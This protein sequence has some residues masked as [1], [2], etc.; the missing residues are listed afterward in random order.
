MSL[1]F[2]TLELENDLNI[3]FGKEE[4]SDTY[5]RELLSGVRLYETGFAVLKNH[6]GTLIDTGGAAGRMTDTHRI[7][8]TNAAGGHTGE[9][10]EVELDNTYM[11]AARSLANGY[12]IYVAAPKREVNAEV[13]ASLTRFLVIFIVA[14]TIVQ[15]IAYRIGVPFGK[16]IGLISGFMKQAAATGNLSLRQEDAVAIDYFKANLDSIDE[17]DELSYNCYMLINVIKDLI[18]DLSALSRELN[19]KGDIDYRIDAGRYKGSCRE[20]AE[21][22]NDMVAG[23]VGDINEILRGITAI[24]DGEDAQL[25]KMSGKKAVFTERF[26]QLETLLDGFVEELRTIAQNAAEGHLNVDVDTSKYT[27]G[28]AK[29][30]E[31]LNAILHAVAKP[32]EEIENVLVKMAVGEFIPMTGG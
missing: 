30:M 24:C 3:A 26:N 19:Q 4:A 12:R 9:V 29:M 18:D 23:M 10:F 5:I 31:E 13:T 20:M 7:K 14:F 1:E 21:G 16:R 17:I 25:R 11:A 22:I 6:E 32:L 2:K 15:V 8:L 27:G 28:W